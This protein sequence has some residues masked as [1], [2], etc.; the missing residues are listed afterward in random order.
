[1]TNFSLHK[2]LKSCRYPVFGSRCASVST[3]SRFLRQEGVGGADVTKNRQREDC[4][5]DDYGAHVGVAELAV[6][7]ALPPGE[8]RSICYALL[9]E[10]RTSVS[11]LECEIA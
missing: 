2:V 10:S 3:C 5:L 4:C 7:H 1:M 9:E 11:L 6:G 8:L